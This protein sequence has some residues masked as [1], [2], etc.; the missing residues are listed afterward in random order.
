[1]LLK[2]VA[3][4]LKVAVANG[5]QYA[6]MIVPHGLQIIIIGVTI[7]FDGVVGVP[8]GF[9]QPLHKGVLQVPKYTEVKVAVFLVGNLDPL[10]VVEL[11]AGTLHA[12]F[13]R[14]QVVII[15]QGAGLVPEGQLEMFAQLAEQLKVAPVQRQSAEQTEAHCR[16]EVPGA[17]AHAGA[18]THIDET[19]AARD[20]QLL[21]DLA[22]ADA[23][24][25]IALQLADGRQA[26]PW[27][28]ATAC[29][30]FQQF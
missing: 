9:Q 3:R 29:E 21:A 16:R 11:G 24:Q 10:V 4:G 25:V 15:K 6:A 18:G 19:Q 17:Q 12:I 23:Q 5:L 26:V 2:V 28:K 22:G 13:Q 7:D 8:V 27:F 20:L 14:V 30:E 1:M